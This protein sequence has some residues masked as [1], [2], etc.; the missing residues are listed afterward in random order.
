[1]HPVTGK[2]SLAWLWDTRNEKYAY[3]YFLLKEE[4][5]IYIGVTCNI[6]TRLLQHWG[7]GYDAFALRRTRDRFY[8]IPHP[9][10]GK[11]NISETNLIRKY[12]PELNRLE[13]PNYIPTPLPKNP[14]YSDQAYEAL[15]PAWNYMKTLR[16]KGY[17]Y[18]WSARD[19][20]EAGYRTI[21]GK[22]FN[23]SSAEKLWKRFGGKGWMENGWMERK[24]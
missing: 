7:K 20:N 19:L 21:T 22:P 3:I 16:D 10:G 17:G 18:G 11:F 5:V 4:K 9:K 6:Y 13:N 2:E 15:R 24:P 12:Q 1:V 14:K 23:P 8:F